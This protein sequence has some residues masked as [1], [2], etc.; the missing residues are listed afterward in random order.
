MVV[1]IAIF[2][3]IEKVI[4]SFGVAHSHG[5]DLGGHDHGDGGHKDLDHSKIHYKKKKKKQ[6]NKKKKKKKKKKE[7]N[8]KK[9]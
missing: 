6:N 7:K 9:E 4:R 8:L 3:C 2:A 1:G 5:G